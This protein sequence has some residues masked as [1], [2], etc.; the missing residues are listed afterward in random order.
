M[1]GCGSTQGGA[2]GQVGRRQFLI[3]TGGVLT[4]PLIARAQPR[5]EG[6]PFRIG[7]PFRFLTDAE[8]RHY[9]TAMREYGWR[10]SEDF[11]FINA[12]VPF[13]V[14][15]AEGIR[16]L[17]AKKPD[18]ILVYTT[19]NALTAHRMS[20]TIPIVMIVSGYPVEAGL[21]KS[22]ARPGMNVTGNALYAGTGV[23][24]KLLELLKDSKPGI[25]SVGVLWGYVPPAFP[26]AEIEPC[27]RDLKRAAAALGVDINI[28][29]VTS[30]DQLAAAL[31][32]ITAE[33]S[34]A[35]LTTAAL[36]HVDWAQV[37]Q[38]AIDRKLPTILDWI[39]PPSEKRMRP[40]LAYAPSDESLIK[41][42]F[43][44]VDRILKG[45][46]P[47]DL[48]IRQ[49]SKFELVVN[50]KMAKAIGIT[51][52]PSIMLRADRVIE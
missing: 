22:L 2:M 44:T 31:D 9:A 33:G 42:A 5:R 51:M 24:G 6:R 34:D 52:P 23:W 29:E 36:R 15:N 16:R 38:F 7:F 12:D 21:A 41:T 20:K 28:F 40:L 13:S 37:M 11:V 39:Q 14:S 30:K 26:S 45:A 50:L 35:L 19:A 4:A 8:R 43:A 1:F 25:K 32:R 18:L 3:A 46:N 10:E 17:M 48:P 27:Y 47:A 49:P